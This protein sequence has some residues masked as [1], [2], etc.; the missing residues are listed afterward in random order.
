[1]LVDYLQEKGIEIS[2]DGIKLLIKSEGKLSD[3]QR[4]FLTQHKFEIIKELQAS[5]DP[6]KFRFSYRFKFTNGDA[7][8]FIS[9]SPPVLARQ[10]IQERLIGR[11]LEEFELLN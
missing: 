7:G 3:V 2:T 4:D 11:Q 1:M 5:N 8:T 6:R 10:K 9:E